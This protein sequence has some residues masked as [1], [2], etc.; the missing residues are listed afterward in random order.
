MWSQLNEHCLSY[1]LQLDYQFAYR[2]GYSCETSVLKLSNNILWSFER[3]EITSLTAL[4]LSAAFETVDHQVLLK[5][6]TD[7][8]GVTDKVLHWFEE[9][10]QPCSFSIL[11]NKSYSEEIDL[12]YS[13]PQGSAAGENVFNL[14]CSTLHE[15]IPEDLQLSRFAD[16]HSVQCEFQAS[17]RQE[18]T[19]C[20]QRVEDCM[21]SIK[22]WMDAV[23]L[24]MNLS[25]TEFIYFGNKIQICKCSAT[26]LN[27]NGDLIERTD[28]I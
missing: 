12:E 11:I 23:Q 24:K 16:N 5:M 13:I 22:Q 25:K 28:V 15:V 18:E 27:V 4:D 2:E 1:N 6:L 14:Y 17:N 3:K 21:L 10:L 26:K 8:F 19:Q 20:I 7:K 9:Y